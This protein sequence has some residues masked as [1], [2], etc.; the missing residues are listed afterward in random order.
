MKK[1]SL[2]LVT[3]LLVGVGCLDRST[4]TAPP[5]EEKAV[6]PA[7]VTDTATPSATTDERK[8]CEALIKSD[9]E[10]SK[11]V[12]RCEQ[13]LASATPKTDAP[14]EPESK[15]S[16]P[17]GGEWQGKI[18]AGNTSPLL[19][20]NQTDYTKARESGKLVILY[21][22]ANWCPECRAE[23]PEMQDAFNTLS[24]SQVIGFRVNYNDNETDDAERDLARE[25]GVAYQHTKVFIKNGERVLK[26]PDSWG[27]ERYLEEILKVL[28]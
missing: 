12:E 25:F 26:A 22:Y 20:F 6:A 24:T 8:K 18:L 19:E 27:Q 11:E 7:A 1:I 2:L 17:A 3:L 15:T 10:G 9:A 14:K 16:K 5:T 13:V 28:Q 23:F 21:F 4:P